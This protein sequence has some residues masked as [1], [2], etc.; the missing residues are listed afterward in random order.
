MPAHA[1]QYDGPKR[2]NTAAEHI[3]RI[4]A[5]RIFEQLRMSGYIIKKKLPARQHSSSD[6]MKPLED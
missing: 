6:F 2:I 3:A 5:E 1:L 4:I